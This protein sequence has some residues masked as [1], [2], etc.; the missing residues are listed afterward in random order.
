M[1]QHLATGVDMQ[2]NNWYIIAY[3][4]KNI[5]RLRRVHYLIRKQ[6]FALQESVFAWFGSKDDLE[7]L[8]Q[9]I[10]KIIQT[11][12]DDVRAYRLQSGRSISLWGRPLLP[13]GVVAY[14]APPIEHTAIIPQSNKKRF[15]INFKA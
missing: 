1:M 3:D 4:I 10:E 15:D 2:E 11:K 14:G 6:S 12:V 8:K 9:E 13:G 5:R 7:R